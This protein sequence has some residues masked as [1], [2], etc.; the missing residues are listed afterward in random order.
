MAGHTPVLRSPIRQISVRTTGAGTCITELFS[1]TAN[2]LT[3][4]DRASGF[5]HFGKAAGKDLSENLQI[6]LFRK[7]DHGQR[8][9]GAASHGVDITKRVD[10]RNLSEGVRVIDDGSEKIYGLHQGKLGRNLID[11]GV[12]GG[13]GGDKHNPGR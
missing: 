13:V 6:C 12:I 7:T 10:R 8:T 5:D 3:A 4:N 1:S 9:D 2:S 11:A